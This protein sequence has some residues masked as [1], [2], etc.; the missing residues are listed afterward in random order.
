M[1]NRDPLAF[2]ANMKKKLA[3]EEGPANGRPNINLGIH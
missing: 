2:F 1:L 3:E